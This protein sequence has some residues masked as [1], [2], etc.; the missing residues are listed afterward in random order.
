MGTK[1]KRTDSTIRRRTVDEVINIGDTTCPPGKPVFIQRAKG[2]PFAEF[3]KVCIQQFRDAGL[4]KPNPSLPETVLRKDCCNKLENKPNYSAFMSRPGEYSNAMLTA[5]NLPLNYKRMPKKNE[6]ICKYTCMNQSM[7]SLYEAYW[8]H[9]LVFPHKD[10]TFWSIWI[11]IADPMQDFFNRRI[12]AYPVGWVESR[13]DDVPKDIA[14]FLLINSLAVH[15]IDTVGKPSDKPLGIDG[16]IVT[17]ILNTN[18]ILASMFSIF[19]GIEVYKEYKWRP[20]K[21]SG[22]KKAILGGTFPE[23]REG[24]AKKF[25]E[26][27]ARNERRA[28]KVKVEDKPTGADEA[29]KLHSQRTASAQQTPP[30]T[31]GKPVFIRGAKEMDIEEY[32]KVYI[33]HLSHA[34]L[35]KSLKRLGK[36]STGHQM[37]LEEM[38]KKARNLGFPVNTL[39][40]KALSQRNEEPLKI[41]EVERRERELSRLHSEYEKRYKAQND[42]QSENEI[43]WRVQNE[44]RLKEQMQF[45]TVVTSCMATAEQTTGPG[46]GG[47]WGSSIRR[48][49]IRR[50]IEDYLRCNGNLPSGEHT[51]KV[52]GAANPFDI[53]V[54]FK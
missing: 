30:E 20:F 17:G 36:N 21:T 12:K 2:M 14:K 27:G 29:T 50:F 23:Y 15:S 7:H 16:F 42:P 33:A 51:V 18:E 38:L 32:G 48:S 10:R 47:A 39:G 13:M 26:I 1:T 34:G 4:L 49:S 8:A 28:L 22:L 52:S 5:V 25:H 31:S 53:K 19:S 3:K 44:E 11:T 43:A 46:G 45:E 9:Y 54:K 6:V 37:G 35:V 41:L 40:A 24:V